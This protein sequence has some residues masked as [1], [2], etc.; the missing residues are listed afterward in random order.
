MNKAITFAE[1]IV[2]ILLASL[3]ALLTSVAGFFGA[4][5]FLQVFRIDPLSVGPLAVL[6]GTVV[7]IVAFVVV[8]FRIV[9]SSR[10]S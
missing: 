10:R 5:E 9:R 1:T 2:P 8:I 6:T 3:I 7:G 4:F